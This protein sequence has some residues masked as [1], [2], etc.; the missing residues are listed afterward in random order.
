MWEMEA[1]TLLAKALFS[2][3]IGALIGLERE[4]FEKVAG[5]RTFMLASLFGML[6][7]HLSADYPGLLA[8]AA[9]IAGGVVLEAYWFRA[10]RS[11]S[12]GLTTVFALV[13][14]FLLGVFAA[15]G[16]FF[17]AASSAV[18]VTLL[19]AGKRHMRRFVTSLTQ[20]E[21]MDALKF[22]IATVVILPLLPNRP[23]DP[24]GV[25][26]PFEMW[27]LAVLVLSVSFL[28]YIAMRVLGP[29]KGTASLGLLGGVASST[30]VASAMAAHVRKSPKLLEAGVFAVVLASSTMFVR[31]LV[32]VTALNTGL[33]LSLALPFAGMTLFGWLACL[34]LWRKREGEAEMELKSSF[35]LMPALK[36]ASLY[37]LISFVSFFAQKFL[38]D[39]GVL[40]TALLAG[41][42]DVDV[43]TT[44]MATLFSGGGIS[45]PTATLAILL[46]AFSN[47]A[48][49]LFL[50]YSMGSEE[51]AKRV[52]AVF[53][54][55]VLL[56]TVLFIFF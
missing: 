50:T 30:A 8:V 16:E 37:T 26:N 2:L 14:S 18:V 44:S 24:W 22:L 54:L 43:V 23:V 27:L 45:R 6:S 19:L 5:L 17:I 56:G 46:G 36:F 3:A 31:S 48:V 20:E 11:E 13:V 53:L 4:R 38:G 10:K 28:G 25:L 41:L 7:A 47:T 21:L 51:M 52:G 15:Q 40:T 33:A 35:A 55:M 1:E 49:K 29:E 42:A 32:V 9:V 34:S 12:A 39:T